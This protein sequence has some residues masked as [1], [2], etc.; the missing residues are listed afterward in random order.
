MWKNGFKYALFMYDANNCV[1]IVYVITTRIIKLYY[2]IIKY[3]LPNEEL[4]IIIIIIMIIIYIILSVHML[5]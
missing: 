2:W 3:T 1:F 5:L 4:F